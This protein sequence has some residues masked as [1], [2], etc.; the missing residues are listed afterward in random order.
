MTAPGGILVTLKVV[1]I[2]DRFQPGSR[3]DLGE[4]QDISQFSIHFY[5]IDDRS[6]QYHVQGSTNGTTWITLVP[7]GT[8]IHGTALHDLVSPTPMRYLHIDVTGGTTG[9]IHGE[10][11]HIME[12]RFFAEGGTAPEPETFYLQ[13]VGAGASDI[14]GNP[15]TAIYIIPNSPPVA[16]DDVTTVDEDGTVNILV[17]SNDTDLMTTWIPRAYQLSVVHPTAR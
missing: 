11:A 9:N 2:L 7:E 5:D 6:Y 15:N 1:Y 16:L 3:F 13:R 4:V 12:I 8:W 17:L 10:F 14:F